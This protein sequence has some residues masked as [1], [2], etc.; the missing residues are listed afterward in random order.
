MSYF[1][2][3]Y[4]HRSRPKRLNGQAPSAA[5]PW[6][7]SYQHTRDPRPEEARALLSVRRLEGRRRS[8]IVPGAILRDGHAQQAA[9]DL[10][11]MRSVVRYDRFHGIALLDIHL[12]DRAYVG[13]RVLHLLCTLTHIDSAAP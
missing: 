8:E 6:F 5:F 3:G 1:A 13:S 12:K 4:S 2:E 10:L 7:E 9:R 11:R